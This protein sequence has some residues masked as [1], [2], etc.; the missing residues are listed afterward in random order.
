MHIFY[1]FYH[2]FHYLTQFFNKVINDKEIPFIFYQLYQGMNTLH[3]FLA[4]L[5]EITVKYYFLFSLLNVCFFH[6]K[7]FIVSDIRE[8]RPLLSFVIKIRTYWKV[9]CRLYCIEHGHIEVNCLF[10][11]YTCSSTIHIWSLHKG[12]FKL[13]Y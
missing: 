8:Y 9:H 11:K 6:T 10:K 2:T 12:F 3:I 1:R 13:K 7:L 5:S 4:H